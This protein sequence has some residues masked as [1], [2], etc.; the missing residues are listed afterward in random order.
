MRAALMMPDFTPPQLEARNAA[1]AGARARL[2][3]AS[4]RRLT[5][6]A[7]QRIDTLLGLPQ[8][9]PALGVD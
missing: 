1:I 3:S 2:G 5:A 6:G 7:V 9:D 8:T 4:G